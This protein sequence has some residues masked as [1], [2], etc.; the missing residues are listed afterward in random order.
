MPRPARISL[1]ALALFAAGCS[2]S[3]GPDN[4]TIFD[5]DSG[6]RYAIGQTVTGIIRTT[7]CGDADVDGTA[8][9]YQFRQAADGP[10][11]I[12]VESPTGSV[13]IF[14]GLIDFNDELIGLELASPGEEIE[15]GGFLEEGT[16]VIV[17]GTESPG[18][19]STYTLSSTRT[20]PSSGPA[21][22]N[23]TVSQAYTVGATVNGA[24]GSGDCLTP[25]DAW[26]D[27]YQFTLAAARTMTI[28][29]ASENFD[30][31]LY[32]FNS[33]GVVLAQNDDAGGS[34]NSRLSISLPAGTYSIGASSFGFRSEGAYTLTTQ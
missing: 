9:F 13:E 18:P 20:L 22:L 16:Y 21:F 3:S 24:L 4:I 5:C 25:D 11:S 7:D 34:L 33:D 1:L 10:V 28:N 12:A 14:V 2:D 6:I 30:A 8:D 31:Y 26:M 17:I 29:L 23:C 27:R 32:L 15:V 19:Q